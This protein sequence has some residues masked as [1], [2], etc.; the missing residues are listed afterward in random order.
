MKRFAVCMTFL[1]AFAGCASKPNPIVDMKGVNRQQYYQDLNEC[2]QYAQQVRSKAAG[3]AVTGAVLG[4]AIG[5]VVGDS[6]T[7]SKGAGVGAITGLARGGSNTQREKDQVVKNCL[8]GRGYKV[9]N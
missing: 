1:V 6:T 2:Q 9:L 8:R 3:G 5:A 4:G 7:A